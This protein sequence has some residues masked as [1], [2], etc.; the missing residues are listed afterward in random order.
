ME[1]K[2][3]LPKT[4]ICFL[5]LFKIGL[6][7]F[8]GGWSI[9]AQMQNDFVHRRAWL[10]DDELMDIVS[11]SRSLPGVMVINTS[12][13]F[14]YR[15]G[16][17]LCAVV[18]AVAVALPSILVLTL[19]TYFYNTIRDNTYVARALVGV[20][21]C[22][23]PI[24]LNATGQL[25]KTALVNRISYFIAA[26]TFILCLFTGISNILLILAGA[27]LGLILRGGTHHAV[28]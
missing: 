17:A 16:G 9:I 23:V 19:V 4:L 15:M 25:K 20:R 21:A 24:I 6:F 12:V 14:G 3:Q 8:G 7:T 28:S 5:V 11:M 27:A 26:G 1:E 13:L 18:C 2:K 22:V 10:T